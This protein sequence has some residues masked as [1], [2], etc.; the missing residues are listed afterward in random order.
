MLLMAGMMTLAGLWSLA[1]Y[2]T[3]GDVR[4]FYGWGR[5]RH[6]DLWL[7]K[8]KGP[9]PVAILIHGGCWR[10]AQGVS[11]SLNPLADDLRRRGI[12][13]WNLEY[14]GINQAHFPA[15]FD[16][17]AA[18]TDK[19]RDLAKRYQLDLSHVVAVGHSAGGHLALWLAARR[20]IAPTSPL[21]RP[22]PV[23]LKAVVSLGGP[24]DLEANKTALAAC[25]SDAMAQL[26]GE[27]AGRPD[28]YADT[29]PARLP[30]PAIPTTL[31][32]GGS[33]DVV[34]PDLV[35]AYAVRVG[36]GAERVVVPGSGHI[37]LITAGAPGWAQAV[38][39]I[40]QGLR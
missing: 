20:A 36:G 22:D 12:A 19:L 24:P 34:P 30:Q 4:A 21:Y 1:S 35:E 28:P 33:D 5:T 16:D 17:V 25:G 23:A 18:G 11:E 29:S 38:A 13:V 6:G 15:T 10:S 14:R 40:Q 26:T 7:P 32:S 8:G 39:A 37:D 9:F 3:P 2:Q 31:I 27:A